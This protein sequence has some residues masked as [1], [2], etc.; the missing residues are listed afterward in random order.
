MAPVTSESDQHTKMGDYVNH[1]TMRGAVFVAAGFIALLAPSA[2]RFL[3]AIIVA[4]VLIINGSTDLYVSARAKPTRWSGVALAAAYIL[5]GGGLLLVTDKTLRAVTLLIAV[6]AVLRGLAVGLAALRNRKARPTWTF[7][8]VRGMLF[9]AIGL[10][11]AVVPE[12]IIAGLIFA[13]AGASIIYGGITLSF[14]LMH[15]TDPEADTLEVGGYI[16]AWLDQ[17][18]VGD[19]MRDDVVDN[20][21][22]E[23]PDATQKQ[24]GF[25]VL[26]VLSTAI[27]T[28]G[29]IADSTAVV[30]GAMLVAPLMTPIMGVSAAIVNGW[31]KR[32]ATSFATVAGGVGVSVATAWI[33]T[34]WTPQLV[35]LAANSQ[36]LSRTSPTLVDMM[37][38]V[39]AGAAG[40]YA[41]VDRRVSSSITGV[42]IAVALVPPLGVVGLTLKAGEFGD[43]GGAFLLFLTNLVSIILVASVVFVIAGLVPIEQFKENRQ[44]MRTVISTV[45]VGALV[46]MLPLVFTSEGIIA[47]AARQSTAQQLTEEWLKDSSDLTLNK[48]VVATND[49]SVVLTGEGTV[50]SVNDLEQSLEEEFKTNISLIVDYFP[51]VRLVP[52]DP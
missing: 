34:A 37:I 13:I 45:A 49:I 24:V 47:S 43:A 42:A 41:T 33:V 22:F 2:S 3:L 19:D 50:P 51:S 14:G 16:K 28:L 8:L 18:D 23:P 44:K 27:A 40:A 5:I 10:V 25:W 6:I 21:F 36:I 1:T 9:I 26:L 17:R 7:D 12:S 38:A 32:V 4:G 46:I 31:A 39:A 29:I 15:A 30:I 20:L 52:S 11:T 48:V 35:P